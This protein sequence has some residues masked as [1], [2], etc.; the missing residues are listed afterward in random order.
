MTESPLT[1]LSVKRRNQHALLT[2]L[3]PKPQISPHDIFLT[4]LDRWLRSSGSKV[5]CNSFYGG[6]NMVKDYK[7][8]KSGWN[9]GIK[10]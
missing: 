3:R 1:K 10:F 5:R 6:N 7:I 9:E 8:E 4:L 2:I